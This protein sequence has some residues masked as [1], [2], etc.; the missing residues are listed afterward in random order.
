M[1][2]GKID[3]GRDPMISVEN[4]T[5]TR[6]LD[7]YIKSDEPHQVGHMLTDSKEADHYHAATPQRTLT[8][9]HQ[10]NHTEFHQEATRECY[11]FFYRIIKPDLRRAYSIRLGQALSPD[12]VAST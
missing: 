10:G 6:A 5:F 1:L 4:L 7:S 3:C 12:H 9:F 11:Q 8:E 2:A